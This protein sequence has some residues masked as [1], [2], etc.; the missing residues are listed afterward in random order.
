M[1]IVLYSL[2]SAKNGKSELSIDFTNC[3]TDF[4]NHQS[5]T[6]EIKL[7]S[8]TIYLPKWDYLNKLR[9]IDTGKEFFIVAS[10]QLSRSAAFNYLMRHAVS[11]L[12]ARI[13]KL[14]EQKR[15]YQQ[16]IKGCIAA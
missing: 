12:D 15:L 3:L 2:R 5:N 9:I 7:P 14:N 16:E 11:K 8:G 4:N 10:K 1:R 13:N 6:L